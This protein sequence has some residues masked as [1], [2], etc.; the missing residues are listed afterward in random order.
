MDGG[1]K[2]PPMQEQQFITPR[3]TQHS[4]LQSA[5]RVE[6]SIAQMGA[7][8]GQMANLVMAQ[9]ETIARIEDD[10]EAGLVDTE[11]GHREMQK[12]LEITKGNRGII[13]KVFALLVFFILLFMFWT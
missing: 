3:A 10:V 5:E 9:G 11:E 8:F 2:Q 7:L 13:L 6:A 12:F 1:P 4:R